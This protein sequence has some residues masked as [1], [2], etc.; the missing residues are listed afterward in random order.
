VSLL[1]DTLKILKGVAKVL[2]CPVVVLTQLSRDV[3]KRAT[4]N[5][6]PIPTMADIRWVGQAENLAEQIFF[7]YWPWKFYK[8]GVPYSTPP[9]EEHY[10]VHVAK[11]RD[12][13]VGVV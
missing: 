4:V 8:A 2:D 9:D 5:R 13:K 7:L 1:E 11:N 10:E 12:G 6:E 3:E